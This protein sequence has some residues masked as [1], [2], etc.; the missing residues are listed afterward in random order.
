MDHMPYEDTGMSPDPEQ[1]LKREG[2]IEEPGRTPQSAEGLDEEERQM[3]G[4]EPGR[5]PGSAEGEDLDE[6]FPNAPRY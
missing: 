4:G 1:E 3:P 5:T 6:L 2:P